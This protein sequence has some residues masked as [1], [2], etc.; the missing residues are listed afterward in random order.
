VHPVQSATEVIFLRDNFY[1]GI[2]QSGR[3]HH[4]FQGLCRICDPVGKQIAIFLQIAG[5]PLREGIDEE[6]DSPY[7]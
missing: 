7:G 1:S 4:S 5:S 2:S 3:Q 6:I